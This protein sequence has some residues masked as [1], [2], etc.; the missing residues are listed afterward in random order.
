MDQ[1]SLPAVVRLL[2]RPVIFVLV[3]LA[4]EWLDE[5]AFGAREAAWPLVRSDLQLS[6]EQIGL[7]LSLPAVIG[8]LIEPL[9][10]ILGDIWRRRLLIVGG[11]VLFT[12]ALALTAVSHNFLLLLIGF[13]VFSPSSGAFVGLS[14]SSLMDLD[15]VRHEQNMARWTFAGSVGVV[16]GAFFLGVLVGLGG[17]WRQFYALAALVSLII[18]L[19]VSR[20]P[21]ASTKTTA[22]DEETEPG[23]M[24]GIRIGLKAIRRPQI[25]RWLVLL[26]FSNLMGDVLYGYLALYFVDVV[27]VSEVQAGIAVAVWTGI[28]LVGGLVMIVLFERVR[29]LRYLQISAWFELVFF[30]G[31]LLIPGFV[32]KLIILTLIGLCNAGWYSVL[33]GQLYSA[34]PGQS[35]TVMA[36]SS[37]TGLVGSVIPFFIGLAADHF[38]LNVSMALL[39][40]G[41]IALLV[42]LPRRVG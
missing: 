40:M 31:F 25:L 18:V 1:I 29:G 14:Q 35:G 36:V 23:L 32:P 6:Y 34:M 12:F 28:G 33:Q 39:I 26:E 27:H 19:I 24:A 22:N 16:S 2:R 42:G 7:L 8:Y 20:F 13:I 30:V 11:G 15:P 37:L 3:L 10:G 41:P 9:I 21:F 17:N 5:F 4:V 38:G